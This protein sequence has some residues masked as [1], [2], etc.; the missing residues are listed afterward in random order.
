MNLHKSEAAYMIDQKDITAFYLSR[1]E[2]RFQT[3]EPERRRIAQ[4]RILIVLGFVLVFGG[5]IAVY[6]YAPPYVPYAAGICIISGLAALVSYF[7]TGADFEKELKSFL[8]QEITRFLG[9]EQGK[10]P[11]GNPLSLRSFQRFGILPSGNQQSLSDYFHGK[12]DGIE[13]DIADALIK[14]KTETRTKDGRTETSIKT[15]FQGPVFRFSYNRPLKGHVILVKDGGKIINFLTRDTFPGERVNLE[16]TEFES[17]FEI[18]ATDQIEARYVLTPRFMERLLGL[19]AYIK[20]KSFGLAFSN[21]FA[22]LTLNTGVDWFE[23]GSLFTKLA[24]QR[25]V[26][27]LIEQL[28]FAFEVTKILNL[29]AKSY[30]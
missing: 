12:Q 5:F 26:E 19:S 18:Y 28:S 9:I 3:L 16:N 10:S 29:T 8:L 7:L 14:H 15:L 11:S 4:K 20:E 27:N 25:R 2:P 23:P 21:N 17:R 30:I 22:Y 13:I 1:I 6:N 24:D